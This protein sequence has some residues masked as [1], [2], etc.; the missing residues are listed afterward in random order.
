MKLFFRILYWI[1]L[2]YIVTC[3]LVSLLIRISPLDF[4][5]SVDADRFDILFFGGI[6][7]A[8][9]LMISRIGFK[10]MNRTEKRN[11]IILGFL[12]SIGCFL[13]FVLYAFTSFGSSLCDYSNGRTLFISR[14]DPS[15]RIIFRYYGCGAVDSSPETPSTAKLKPFTRVFNYITPVD[16]SK[17]NKEEWIRVEEE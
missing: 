13:I 5:S 17:I 7:A 16:T 14:T 8:I 15:I 9:L 4:A 12:M 2:L 10:T 3:L 1:S 6:P 11:A